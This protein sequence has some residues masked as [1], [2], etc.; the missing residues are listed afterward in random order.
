ME[1]GEG[2]L[3]AEGRGEDF[4][5]RNG[6]AGRCRFHFKYMGTKR[7]NLLFA[8]AKLEAENNLEKTM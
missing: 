4:R 5:Y 6:E 8:I 2:V 7:R 1:I 3:E